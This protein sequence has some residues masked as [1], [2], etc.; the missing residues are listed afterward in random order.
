ME[1]GNENQSNRGQ[2][3]T[4][5]LRCLYQYKLHQH[6][7]IYKR[8]FHRG[9]VT[10]GTACGPA[11]NGLLRA[12]ERV[13]MTRA[14]CVV[15][16]DTSPHNNQNL[17]GLRFHI[18]KIIKS[19]H[20]QALDGV[21]ASHYCRNLSEVHRRRGFSSLAPFQ[22]LYMYSIKKALMLHKRQTSGMGKSIVSPVLGE[23]SLQH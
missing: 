23:G 1:C 3:C 7:S 13:K 4:Q 11:H 2:R 17:S 5:D 6:K 18:N 9:E 19:A 12:S 20:N 21:Q 10:R 15:V 14:R 8:V 22:I 16:I